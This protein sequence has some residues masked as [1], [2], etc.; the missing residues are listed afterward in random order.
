MGRQATRQVTLRIENLCHR[1]AGIQRRAR[2]PGSKGAAQ[3]PVSDENDILGRR[4]LRAGRDAEGDLLAF[5]QFTESL[6]GDVRGVG[7]DISADALFDGAETLWPA[8]N[9]FTILDAM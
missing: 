9:H 8:L 6:G 1:R 5:H 3:V 4:P 2:K 7:G